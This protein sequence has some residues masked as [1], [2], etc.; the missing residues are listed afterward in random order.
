MYFALLADHSVKIKEI[1]KRDKYL[2]LARELKK[3][4]EYES[5]SDTNCGWCTRDYPQRIGKGMGKLGNKWS[6]GN[7]ADYSLIKIGQNTERSPDDF[8]RLNVKRIN[9]IEETTVP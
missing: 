1:E 6:S 7:H 8:R 4:I 3:T 5:D 2:D 9:S